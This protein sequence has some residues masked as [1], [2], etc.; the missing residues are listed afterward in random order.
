[1][2]MERP[3]AA[4]MAARSPSPELQDPGGA[5]QLPDPVHER[6][7]PGGGLAADPG[8]EPGGDA[9]AG[10]RGDQPGSAGDRQVVR[11]D[12]Q[13]RAGMDPRPV[14]HAPGPGRHQADAGLPACR[15][16]LRQDLVLGHHR[17]RGRRGLEHLP[18]LHAGD[19]DAR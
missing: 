17:R 15:A 4:A 16:L 12:R 6:A 2:S 9:H 10:Q 3:T 5:A 18:F 13:R 7:E 8:G 11:A 1:M 19:R 14:L